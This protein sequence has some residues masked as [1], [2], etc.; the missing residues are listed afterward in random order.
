[1]GLGV[2]GVWGLGF[3]VCGVSGFVIWDLWG[4]WFGV[5]S[6][7]GLWFGG[8]YG[9]VTRCCRRMRALNP[10]PEASSSVVPYT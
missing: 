9:R 2:C 6:V 7:W 10:A 8:V 1:M 4:L 3:G 5:W